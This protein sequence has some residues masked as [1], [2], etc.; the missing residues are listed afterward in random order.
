MRNK[1]TVLVLL[2]LALCSPVFAQEKAA[3]PCGVRELDPETARMIDVLT[4]RLRP[5]SLADVQPVRIPV[6]FHVI[7]SGKEGRVASRHIRTLV[8]R[9]NWAFRGTPYS[10]YLERI[11][12]RNNPAWFKDCGPGS[13]NEAAMKKRLARDPKRV[14]NMYSCKP[15]IPTEGGGFYV[16]GYSSF[17]LDYDEGSHMH[18]VLL[19]PSGLPGGT[20]PRYNTYG[21]AAH[22]VGHYL[23]LL[24]TFQGGCG[25]NGDRVEDT[26]PQAEP[27]NSCKPGIDTCA[28]AAGPDDAHNFMNYSDDRC[29]QHFTPGQIERT[30]LLTGTYR[31][32]LVPW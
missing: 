10:F 31:P 19:N 12:R 25:A 30:I 8:S 32:T 9:L 24:H 27:H 21:I 6:A 16:T 2:S 13:R 26:P 4:E 29:M 5:E 23:G 15:F 11:D 14:L 1:L 17:P 28:D 3:V 18:G 7:T 20:D 22:E